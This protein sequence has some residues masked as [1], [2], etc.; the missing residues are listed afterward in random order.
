METSFQ[1]HAAACFT[2]LGNIPVYQFG[3]GVTRHYGRPSVLTKGIFPASF[4]L[5]QSDEKSS[6]ILLMKQTTKQAMS[7]VENYICFL[8]HLRRH[9]L[10]WLDDCRLRS[11]KIVK[12]SCR[13]LCYSQMC[14]RL[15]EGTEG[16]FR[17]ARKCRQFLA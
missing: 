15:P 10:A 7:K 13:S 6:R 14:H 4:D 11:G 16:N 9:T 1:L 17:S 12:E 2:K 5:L 8:V 3:S